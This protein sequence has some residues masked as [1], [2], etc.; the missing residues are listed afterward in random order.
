[1]L[2]VPAYISSKSFHSQKCPLPK[3]LSFLDFYNLLGKEQCCKGSWVKQAMRPA[4][5]QDR[6]G[7]P[8]D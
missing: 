8:L 5:S 1:M 4:G 2:V 6:P 7:L 3:C